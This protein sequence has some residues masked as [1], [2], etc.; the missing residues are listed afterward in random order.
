M[1]KLEISKNSRVPLY[2]Q[3]K[4][5][6]IHRISTGD[7]RSLEE[8][9]RLVDLTR[10]LGISYETVRRAYRELKEEG[11]ISISR[12]R[13]TTVSPVDIRN[14]ARLSD[15]PMSN[16]QLAEAQKTLLLRFIRNQM[17]LKGI[18]KLI[19]EQYRELKKKE[20]D[21]F[22]VF[23]E[24]SRYQ[25]SRVSKLLGP[26]LGTRVMPVV[27]KDLGRIYQRM[28]GS[29][30]P[31][32]VITTGF[33]LKA[34]RNVVAEDSLDVYALI[35]NMSERDRRVL[36]SCHQTTRFGIICRDADAIPIYEAL[37]RA[38]L[39]EAHL[40]ISSCTI[41]N[42]NE[43][44]NILRSAD[45]LIATP[46]VMNRIKKDLPD[47]LPVIDM[48]DAVDPMSLKIIKDN[49]MEKRALLV[50]SS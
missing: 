50:S 49:I 4:D 18:T 41:T 48:F 34:V 35:L 24:C 3:V 46:P 2:R 28:K 36:Y 17:D 14:N 25:A 11:F 42:K 22:V 9:P 30:R 8:M 39:K 1:L 29:R 12:G 20:D 40:N 16:T 23:C 33:H 31:L 38:E 27:L 13:R 47:K 6:F 5:T 21:S 10:E 15:I 45:L 7:I 19:S 32:A 43:V 44:K 37:L 26:E